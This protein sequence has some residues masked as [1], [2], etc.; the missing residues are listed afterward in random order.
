MYVIRNKDAREGE[1]YN[2]LSDELRGDVEALVASLALEE[3][4][5]E[6]GR[7]GSAGGRNEG[8]PGGEQGD[9]SSVGLSEHDRIRQAVDEIKMV[10]GDGFG[11]DQIYEAVL[12]ADFNTERAI[13]FLLA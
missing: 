6:G 3:E 8:R 12:A 11:E 2:A 1:E 9:A 10:L 5:D 4:V 13:N 7:G